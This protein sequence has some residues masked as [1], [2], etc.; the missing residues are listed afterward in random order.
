M[1]DGSKNGISYQNLANCDLYLIRMLKERNLSLKTI[2]NFLT[3]LEKIGL[4]Y[5]RLVK[6]GIIKLNS[7]DPNC[8][9]SPNK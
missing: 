2:S 4:A 9:E 7:E 5:N 8:Y 6:T 1:K 3:S